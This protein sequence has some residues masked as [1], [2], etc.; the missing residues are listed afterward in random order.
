MREEL[1]DAGEAEL[2]QLRAGLE[3]RESDAKAQA[4]SLSAAA[5][6]AAMTMQALHEQQQRLAGL[7]ARE[8]STQ[9]LELQLAIQQDALQ[10]QEDD[11]RARQHSLSLTQEQDRKSVV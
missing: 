6:R 9:K 5:E 3:R 2:S 10:A 7:E 11:L 1:I 4:E 8:S